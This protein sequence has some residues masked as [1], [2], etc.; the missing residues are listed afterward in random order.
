MTKILD[1]Q[2][3]PVELVH[4]RCLELIDASNGLPAAVALWT[5]REPKLELQ[6]IGKGKAFPLTAI[7]T[8]RQTVL[9]RIT[10]TIG[11]PM[12]AAF[13]RKQGNQ[14]S[15]DFV[16]KQFPY[17]EMARGVTQLEERL[18][19]LSWWKAILTG[20]GLQRGDS[21]AIPVEDYPILL[22][23]IQERIG[24]IVK[25]HA[26]EVRVAEE[27]EKARQKEQA[28]QHAQTAAAPVAVADPPEPAQPEE[29]SD[30]G[31]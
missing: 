17:A 20:N 23:Q 1:Q 19:E 12:M 4:Q 28:Q 10:E 11:T 9:S 30:A 24:Q 5:Y 7:E 18:N 31:G 27:A 26:Q 25:E 21:T 14:L 16:T 3:I 6:L 2:P 22:R 29:S 8:Y 13:W 15:M